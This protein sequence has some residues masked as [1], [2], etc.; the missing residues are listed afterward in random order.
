MADSTTV[1]ERYRFLISVS[2]GWVAL[3]A[4]QPSQAR[5]SDEYNRQ[6][7]AAVRACVLQK[8]RAAGNN[9][10]ESQVQVQEG[11]FWGWINRQQGAR[12]E[13]SKPAITVYYRIPFN[14]GES[15]QDARLAQLKASC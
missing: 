6:Y 15:N 3:L 11:S 4:A 2:L 12:F 10:D 8:A 9:V 1:K 7:A 13:K 5:V 14:T